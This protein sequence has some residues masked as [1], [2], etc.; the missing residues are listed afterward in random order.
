MEKILDI[1][2]HT[3]LRKLEDMV[4]NRT[5]YTLDHAELNIYETHQKT[6]EVYLTF[7]NP[8]LASMITG[9]KIMHLRGLS[10]F[11]FLPGQSVVLP[12]NETMKI[13]FPEATEQSPTQCLA[14]SLSQDKISEVTNFLNENSPIVDTHEGWS[15]TNENFFF[16]HDEGIHLLISRLIYIFTE[17]NNAKK[18]FADFALK[19]LIIRLMQTKARLFL[20]N[21]FQ[22]EAASNRFAY[23]LKYIHENIYKALSVKELSEKACMSESN[24]YRS[25]KNQFGISPVEYINQQRIELAQQLLHNIENTIADVSFACGFNNVNHFNKL[26]KK[27]TGKTPSLFRKEVFQSNSHT[28]IPLSFIFDNQAF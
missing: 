7:S 3:R 8:V 26:F 18:V 14:L 28:K 4:E 9:K 15:F 27:Q 21:N 22:K 5:A 19:E 10:T 17:N 2:K 23:I 1:S 12:S 24:F 20:M 11:D 25:F 6:K 13:D 16:T